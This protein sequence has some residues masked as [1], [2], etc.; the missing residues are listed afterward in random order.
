MTIFVTPYDALCEIIL[1]LLNKYTNQA[2][3]ALHL[4]EHLKLL[5]YFELGHQIWTRHLQSCQTRAQ[6]SVYSLHL[7]MVSLKFHYKQS[8]GQ[9]FHKFFMSK[10]LGGRDCL[11]SKA[12]AFLAA[13][14][15]SNS[16]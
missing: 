3:M 2:D 6:M 13:L 15:V 7:T 8:N 14:I 16:L 4:H 9:V 12:K 5:K 1:L 11:I 10:P